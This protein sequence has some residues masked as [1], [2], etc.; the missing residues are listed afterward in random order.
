MTHSETITEY[1]LTEHARLEMARRQ[2]NENDVARVLVA[3]EQSEIVREGRTVYQSRMV[4]G[5]PP[6]TCLLRV[7]GDTDR[8]PPEVVT[9]CRTSKIVKYWRAKQ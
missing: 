2:I 4:L 8:I 3:P 1:R 9:V 7:F 5:R 6:K